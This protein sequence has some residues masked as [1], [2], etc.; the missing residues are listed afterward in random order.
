MSTENNRLNTQRVR[1]SFGKAAADYDRYAVLQRTITE[2]LLESFELIDI[3]PRRVLDLGAGTGFGARLLKQQFKRASLVQVDLSHDMLALSRQ[4]SPRFF[5]GQQF[6]CADASR[7]PFQTAQFDMIFSSLML[8]WCSN[9]DEVFTELA[10]LLKPG[11][12]F[13]FASLGPDTLKELR[14]CWRRVDD[15]V[16]V[17]TFIDM[18]DIGDALIR[19]GL[20]EP[21]LGVEHIKLL[22]DDATTLMRELKGIGARNANTGQRTTL[23]GKQRLQQVLAHYESFRSD[24]KLPATYEAIYGHCWKSATV[25][26]TGH[27]QELVV[28]LDGLRQQLKQRRGNQGQ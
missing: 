23:T 20:S 24:G 28:S 14:E 25:R 10:G 3:N 27:Q 6:V 21:V 19:S 18:H 1:R 5:S 22:Y 13:I 4:N 2:R 7:L 9:L 12:L 17:N 26:D 8:Q 11:G 15:D 16:H